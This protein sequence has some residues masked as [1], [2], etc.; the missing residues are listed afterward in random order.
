MRR[1]TASILAVIGAIVAA[2][3]A[4]VMAD[5]FPKARGFAAEAIVYK[6]QHRQLIVLNPIAYAEPETTAGRAA[7]PARGN[8]GS[9]K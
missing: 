1:S 7:L 2:T 4:A 6:M 5:T 3:P 8:G 9:A